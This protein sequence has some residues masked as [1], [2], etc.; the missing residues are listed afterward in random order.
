[1]RKVLALKKQPAVMALYWWS[2]W[3]HH[4]YQSSQDEMDVVARYRHVT[5]LMLDGRLAVMPS[6]RSHTWIG[7]MAII[8]ARPAQYSPAN[9]QNATRACLCSQD[10]TSSPVYAVSSFIGGLVRSCQIA[11]VPE[12]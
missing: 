11:C 8:A 3:H 10:D 12:A 7:S 2:P 6:C 1:M 9:V 5:S 4:F